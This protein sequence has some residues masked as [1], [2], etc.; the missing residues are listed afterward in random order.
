MQMSQNTYNVF[1]NADQVAKRHEIQSKYDWE[2]VYTREGKAWK[3]RVYVAFETVE[4]ARTLYH[5]LHAMG[6]VALRN[7]LD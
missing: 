6:M 3:N 4:Q 1:A 2:P 5:S 7:W